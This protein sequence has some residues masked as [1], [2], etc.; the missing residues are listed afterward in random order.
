MSWLQKPCTLISQFWPFPTGKNCLFWSLL[1][2]IH[3][4]Q[5]LFQL[6]CVNTMGYMTADMSWRMCVVVRQIQSKSKCTIQIHIWI[7]T[8]MNICFRSKYSCS[9]EVPWEVVEWQGHSAVS[10]FCC[11]AP[12]YPYQVSCHFILFLFCFVFQTKKVLQ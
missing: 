12:S 3:I 5:M 4:L 11:Q 9:W 2:H 1:N 7:N 8:D 10:C 6:S